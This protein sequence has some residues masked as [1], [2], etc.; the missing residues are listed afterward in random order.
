MRVARSGFVVAGIGVLVS[1][2]M[3]TSQAGASRAVL[4]DAPAAVSAA[5]DDDALT[6]ASSGDH[7]DHGRADQTDTNCPGRKHACGINGRYVCCDFETECCR[8]KPH[9]TYCAPKGD[10]AC[11]GTKPSPP[12]PVP[13]PG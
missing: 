7:D 3:A 10:K 5:N 12:V 13:S 6:L 9:K 4:E 11:A 8:R 1:V 2:L